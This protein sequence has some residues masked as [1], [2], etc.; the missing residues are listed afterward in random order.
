MDFVEFFNYNSIIMDMFIAEYND[1]GADCIR[2]EAPASPTGGR[3][4]QS[5]S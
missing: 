2:G 1:D 3:G 5:E 4:E